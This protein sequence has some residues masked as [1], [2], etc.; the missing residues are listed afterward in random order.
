MNRK[1]VFNVIALCLVLCLM[2]GWCAEKALAAAAAPKAP[3]GGKAVG[4]KG[5]S[6]MMEKKGIEGLFKGKGLDEKRKPSKVQKWL[7]V[8]SIAVMIIVVKYL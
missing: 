2:I 7:G 4:A 6:D 1:R 5:G 3:A 8:G